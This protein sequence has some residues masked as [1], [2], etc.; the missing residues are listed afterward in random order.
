A[1]ARLGALLL[2]PVPLPALRDA[3]RELG[4]LRGLRVLAGVV[5]GVLA[6]LPEDRA[7]RREP[8]L[9]PRLPG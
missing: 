1:P 5:V 6:G 3:L 2:H 7:A 4:P 9:L 8:P